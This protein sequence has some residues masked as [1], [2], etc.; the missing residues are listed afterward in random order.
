VHVLNF[1]P[2]ADGLALHHVRLPHCKILDAL[3][4][5]DLHFLSRERR[6]EGIRDLAALF[7]APLMSRCF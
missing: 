5:E 3:N 6:Q 7:A 4:G 2:V 1:L